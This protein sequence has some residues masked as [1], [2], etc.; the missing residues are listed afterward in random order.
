MTNK[1]KLTKLENIKA[2]LLDDS[3]HISTINTKIQSV[4]DNFADLIKYINTDARKTSIEGY[5]ESS[6]NFDYNLSNKR[7][8]EVNSFSLFCFVNSNM[9]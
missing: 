4:A 5:K 8:K 1:Q 6:Q 9:W 3:E 7:L 2:D